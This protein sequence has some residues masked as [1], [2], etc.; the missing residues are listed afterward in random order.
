MPRLPSVTTRGLV[1]FPETRGFVEDRQVG[2]HLT[3]RHPVRGTSVTVPVHTGIDFGRDLAA[4]II[5]N[6]RFT[7][8]DFMR[9]R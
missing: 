8:E 4:R 5:K 9:L 1:R 2:S 3:L 6:A 7:A